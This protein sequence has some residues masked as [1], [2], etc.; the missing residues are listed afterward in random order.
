MTY[1]ALFVVGSHYTIIRE[2]RLKTKPIHWRELQSQCPNQTVPEAHLP[3]IFWLTQELINALC[4]LSELELS[5]LLFSMTH[6]NK[7]QGKSSLKIR[8][9][10]Q[11]CLMIWT[12]Q[13]RQGQKVSIGLGNICDLGKISVSAGGEVAERTLCRLLLDIWGDRG[14][15][16]C[17]PL[18]FEG[19]KQS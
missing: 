11:Q 14:P 12:C 7:C 5:F 10:T 17:E 3:L 13:T 8:E 18:C 19:H 15:W 4:C 2:N 9:Q 6:S 1:K 16:S